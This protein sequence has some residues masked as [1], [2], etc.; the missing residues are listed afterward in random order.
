LNKNKNQILD[1]PEKI[2]KKFFYKRNINH[3]ST[4][5]K[6]NLFDKFGRYDESFSAKADYEKWLCFLNNGVVFKKSPV[7]V[8][9]FHWFDG[10]SSS[11][12]TENIRKKE[13]KAVIKKYYTWYELIYFN[14]LNNIKNIKKKYKF[15]RT[16][17]R[18]FRKIVPLSIRKWGK[19]VYNR[20]NSY[21]NKKN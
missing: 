16:L 1:F 17:R 5:I 7:I 3:Q 13:I 8:S 10:I 19:R 6:R 14:I 20:I 18:L 15:E 21:I 11:E 4:F 9:N 12:E 2:D